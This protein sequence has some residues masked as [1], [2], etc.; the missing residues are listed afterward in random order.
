MTTEELKKEI[1]RYYVVKKLIERQEAP[2]IDPN[3]IGKVEYY[4]D[5]MPLLAKALRILMTDKYRH[6]IKDIAIVSPKPSTYKVT[7]NNDYF[8]YLVYNA[9]SVTANVDGKNYSLVNLEEAQRASNAIT[10]L[11]KFSTANIVKQESE[12]GE[13]ELNSVEGGGFGSGGSMPTG[14]DIGIPGADDGDGSSSTDGS[15]VG[16]KTEDPNFDIDKILNTK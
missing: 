1:I 16:G 11:L 9:G 6:F 15:E 12:A 10:E 5:R 7:L 4:T 2:K 3:R 14:D 8:I 13:N